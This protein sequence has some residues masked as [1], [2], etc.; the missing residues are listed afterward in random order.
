MHLY[1]KF[2]LAVMA[3]SFFSLSA[4]GQTAKSQCPAGYELVGQY[5]QDSKT[6]D[7]VLPK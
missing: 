5:C 1:V 6:G 3:V 7:V 4:A 2:V